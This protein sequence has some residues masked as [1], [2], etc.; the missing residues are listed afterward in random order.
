MGG[1]HASTADGG[2]GEGISFLD[3][4]AKLRLTDILTTPRRNGQRRQSYMIIGNP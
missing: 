3:R 1:G 2:A 4:L